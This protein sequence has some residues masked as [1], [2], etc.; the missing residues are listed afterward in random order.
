MPNLTNEELDEYL[1]L[2]AE[3]ETKAKEKKDPVKD[4][5]NWILIVILSVVQI[6]LSCLS[7]VNGD[8]Q[9]IHII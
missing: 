2:N 7:T 5:M 8:V 9:F 3:E 6:A 1:R 4:N